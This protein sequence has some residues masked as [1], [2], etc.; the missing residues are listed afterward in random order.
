MIIAT[1]LGIFG[2]SLAYFVDELMA[3][4]KPPIYY[5][6]TFTIISVFIYLVIPI[7]SFLMIRAK[8]IDKEFTLPYT[9]GFGIIGVVISIW[10]VFVCLMW[11]G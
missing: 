1:A 8:K 6:T 2:Q 10:S 11:W 7:F 9:L 5:L 3:N 4:T